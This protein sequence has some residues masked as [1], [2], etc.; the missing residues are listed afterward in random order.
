M[1]NDTHK[2]ED[3]ASETGD[4][5]YLRRILQIIIILNT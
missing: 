1:E 3:E 2:D 4:K 5:I